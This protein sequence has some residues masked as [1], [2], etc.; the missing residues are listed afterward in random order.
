MWEKMIVVGKVPNN[1]GCVDQGPMEQ[2]KCEP[3]IYD[4]DL[5]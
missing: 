2:L 1:C 5:F 4:E 3:E